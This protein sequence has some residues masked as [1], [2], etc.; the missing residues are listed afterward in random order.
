MIVIST[1]GG[2]T[3]KS[4]CPPGTDPTQG[5]PANNDREALDIFFDYT[6]HVAD[7]GE[8][9]WARLPG[10]IEIGSGSGRTI[11]VLDYDKINA[12]FNCKGCWSYRWR[13]IS[14]SEARENSLPVG[15]E[16]D[17]SP[18]YLCRLYHEGHILI[19]KAK[20]NENRCWVQFDGREH[21]YNGE[22][23]VMTNPNREANLRWV[24]GPGDY[25]MPDNAI[26]AGRT[27]I[28]REPLYIGRCTI[29]GQGYT[30]VV[31]GYIQPSKKEFRVPFGGGG[32]ACSEYEILVC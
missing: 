1:S 15:N 24:R 31:P 21:S 26:T 12:V 32:H 19:G 29:R 22:F 16:I 13:H 3:K 23:E 10:N 7:W 11:S 30:S 6:S 25:R 2:I 8:C 17:G 5:P 14:K 18:F 28:E 20:P 27:A 9:Y 4:T